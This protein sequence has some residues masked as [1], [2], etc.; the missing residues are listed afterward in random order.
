M[1]ISRFILYAILVSISIISCKKNRTR[2][3]SD[4]KNDIDSLSYYAGIFAGYTLKNLEDTE[5]NEDIFYQGVKEVFNNKEFKLKKAEIDY[6][7]GRY[8][9]K[10]RKIEAEKYLKLGEAFLSKNKM[11][12]NIITTPSGLQYEVIEKGSGETPKLNDKVIIKFIGSTYNGIEF[13]N[14][15][16]S[17]Y[18][19]TLIINKNNILPGLFEAFQLMKTGGKYKV[20]IPGGLAFGSNTPPINGVKPNMVIIY[21]IDLI[22]IVK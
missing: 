19:D 14:S 6:N 10:L 21:D 16:K 13:A 20:F 3:E 18:Y 4:L 2:G 7:I 12:N 11:N 1:K 22:S 5:V 15:Y 17:G 8:F 9:D